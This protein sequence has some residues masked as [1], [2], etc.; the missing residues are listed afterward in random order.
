[1]L[2]ILTQ[3]NF[4]AKVKR[5]REMRE[6]REERKFFARKNLEMSD[7]ICSRVY[8]GTWPTDCRGRHSKRV[9]CED[10]TTYLP[11]LITENISS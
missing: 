1:M 11:A 7:L 2:E 6:S 9:A 10:V 3:W 5:V 4:L 8:S